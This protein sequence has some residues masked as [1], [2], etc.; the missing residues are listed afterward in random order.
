[1][2]G[3]CFLLVVISASAEKYS[4]D[5]DVLQTL[6]SKPTWLRL[7]H[8]EPVSRWSKQLKSAIV[9]PEF[10]LSPEGRENPKAELIATLAALQQRL[11]GRPDNHAQCRFRSRFLWLLQQGVIEDEPRIECPAFRVFSEDES[12]ESI[13]V[14]LATGY[15]G[16]PASYYGHILLKFNSGEGS[17]KTRLL[18][19]SI[20]YGAIVPKNVDPVSYIFNGVLGGYEGGFTHIQYYFHNHNYGENELRDLWEYEL[21]LSQAETALL[22]A[23]A[24]ELIGKKYDYYFLRRNCAFRMGK[25]LEVVEGVDVVPENYAY[26]IPQALVQRI[27]EANIGGHPLLKSVRYIPSRQSR[28]YQR[29]EQLD[30]EERRVLAAFVSSKSIN[31]VAGY[32]DLSL[33]SR[34][35]V[36][37]ATLD[38]FQYLAAQETQDF[39]DN[40]Y[41]EALALRYALPT[42]TAQ[43]TPVNLPASPHV[44]R[45]PSNF[46]MGLMSNSRTGE[47]L[48]I[49][50]RPA[51]YDVLDSGAGQVKNGTL[52]MAELAV[53][54]NDEAVSLRHFDVFRVASVESPNTGLAGDG[55]KAWKLKAGVEQ[56]RLDCKN[57]LIAR[58]Q[59]DRGYSVGPTENIQLTMLAGGAIQ[60]NKHGEGWGFGRLSAFSVAHFGRLSFQAG[61]ETR[62]YIGGELQ[63][64]RI[65]A[66]LEARYAR[67]KQHEFRAKFQH[68]QAN[69]FSLS[70][71]FYW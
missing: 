54:L 52:T 22:T 32:A 56:Q 46:K 21:N 67:G 39:L 8:Y 69:E 55:G 45:K 4:F 11:D 26:T 38:Y 42:S 34:L 15:L 71:G 24:W 65:V 58:I 13:S 43:I 19:Q 1:M 36:L 14:V 16:N 20:N 31:S 68:N 23:H 57:C 18:D 35:H 37:D 51:Y 48:E 61:V 9:S 17:S 10:F 50:L 25:I 70:Y 33:Q 59:G 7:L 41:Y 60:N 66:M 49:T 6:A 64:T 2:A 5:E 47:A 3:L 44:G 53:S 29:Y 40:R 62:R 12:I 28:F 27:S 30:T 63:K